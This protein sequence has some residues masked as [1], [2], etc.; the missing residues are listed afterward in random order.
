MKNI[1]L[2]LFLSLIGI[3]INA[4]PSEDKLTEL[5]RWTD[6]RFPAAIAAMKAQRDERY[7]EQEA[8]SEREERNIDARITTLQSGDAACQARIR[9]LE[10]KASLKDTSK[11]TRKQQQ[12]LQDLAQRSIEAANKYFNRSYCVQQNCSNHFNLQITCVRCGIARYCNKRCQQADNN[13]HELSCAQWHR[14]MI[15]PK[16]TEE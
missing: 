11:P 13:D 16:K 7:T 3:G 1:F 9:Y 14:K 12:R 8:L 6:N 5:R 2:A 4:N 15:A 10:M